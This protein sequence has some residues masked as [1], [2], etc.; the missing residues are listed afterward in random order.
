MDTNTIMLIALAVILVLSAVVI[1]LVNRGS[2][3]E[4]VEHIEEDEDVEVV[5]DTKT[6]RTREDT[7]Q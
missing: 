1:W 2:G 6:T 7:R 4:R 5:E 3:V